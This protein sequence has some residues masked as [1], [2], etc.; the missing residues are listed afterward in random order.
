MILGGRYELLEKIGGG[1][2]AIVYKAKCHLLKRYVAVKILR[3]E[4]V[5]DDEFVTRFRRE[6]QAAASLS[7]PNIVNIYDV[8]EE[9]GIYYIV[10]EYVDGGTL[11]DYIKKKGSLDPEETID[12]GLHICSAIKHAHDNKI[13]HRDIKPQNIL[14]DSDG[15]IKV[16]DFGIARAVTSTTV[17]MAGSNVMGSVHYFSPEQARGGYV[18]EKS[19]LYSLGVVLFEMCTGN[20]PFNGDSA[21]SIALKHIQEEIVWPNDICDHIPRSLQAIIKKALEKEQCMRYQSAQEMMDDLRRA[22]VEPDGDFVVTNISSDMPTQAINPVKI[23]NTDAVDKNGDNE[24]KEKPKKNKV[25]LYL[26]PIG[27]LLAFLIFIGSKIYINNF[28]IIEEVV[29]DITGLSIEE[30]EN[31]L[32]AK[33]LGLDIVGNKNSKDIGEGRIISQDPV[34]GTKIK[35]SSNI[36]VIVSLGPKTTIVPNVVGKSE[37]EAI[38]ELENAHLEVTSREYKADDE[39]PR[40]FVIAQSIQ[41]DTEVLDGTTIDLVISDGPKVSTVKVSKYTDLQLDVARQLIVSDNLKEGNI[42]QIYSDTVP[43]GIVIKQKPEQ[44]VYV[45]ENRKIDLWVSMGSRPN[46]PKKLEIPLTGEYSNGKDKVVVKIER[47]DNRSIIHEREYSVDEGVAV[48]ELSERGVVDYNIYIDDQLTQK[49]TIDF[50]KK[51]ED[52]K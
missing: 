6:S 47:A 45:E 31:I 30:A 24:N 44:G 37:Q 23:N 8:G 15:S 38:M 20:V 48:I 25:V 14:M 16:A 27:L 3:P 1:G 13:V 40:G 26:L 17:T 19:D 33:Q 10:M 41:H 50:T 28:M 21:V 22:L 4:L 34:A 35:V 5:E 51:E 11:K 18:D 46:Y 2:M 32:R 43:K 9:D 42:F 12:I 49:I 29:P 52:Q 39:Y 7:H 36:N